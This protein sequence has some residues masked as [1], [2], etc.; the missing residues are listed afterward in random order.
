MNISLTESFLDTFGLK[1]AGSVAGVE[2][3]TSDGAAG[4]LMAAM[5]RELPKDVAA[6]VS[7]LLKSG[8]VVAAYRSSGP[9]SYLF[10]KIRD[11]GLARDTRA[12]F[13]PRTGKIWAVMDN[14][15]SWMRT[16]A[17]E[18]SESV[19]HEIN[20]ML[21]NYRNQECMAEHGASLG[22]FYA[23]MWTSLF[24]VKVEARPAIKVMALM[25]RLFDVSP[26][27]PADSLVQLSAA[28]KAN[29]PGVDEMKVLRHLGFV[30]AFLESPGNFARAY[31]RTPMMQD[32][33]EAVLAGYAAIGD[34]DPD[35]FPMQECVIPS[36]PL[37]VHL[38]K[39][40]A[41]PVDRWPS[42]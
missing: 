2:M 27:A 34:R 42:K 29:F 7:N 18:L 10:R 16:D 11:D 5:E 31:S 19:M 22:R 25:H 32:A 12:L 36:E 38:G 6:G 40:P 35:T 20:H 15:E 26:E 3:R 8:R 30:K 41:L 24:D 14:N 4:T 9:A 21:F 17:A 37:C 13:D 1:P 39:T 23:T 28:M 33:R